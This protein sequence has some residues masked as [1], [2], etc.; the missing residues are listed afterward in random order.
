MYNALLT[1]RVWDSGTQILASQTPSLALFLNCEHG[2]HISHNISR[3][4][5]IAAVYRVTRSDGTMG[6]K[7]EIDPRAYEFDGVKLLDSYYNVYHQKNII[8]DRRRNFN[9]FPRASKILVSPLV[10]RYVY[11]PRN[12]WNHLI[13]EKYLL[14]NINNFICA[15]HPICTMIRARQNHTAAK[16]TIAP[17]R[18]KC[19]AVDKIR[20]I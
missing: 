15:R 16:N 2:E 13:I 6:E 9:I 4:H 19:S 3:R 5:T 12:A 10:T 18:F 14:I 11:N 20:V 8:G 1:T 7:T 17:F